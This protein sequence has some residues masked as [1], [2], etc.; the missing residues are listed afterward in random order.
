M[1]IS[2][3]KMYSQTNFP[4]SKLLKMLFLVVFLNLVIPLQKKILMTRLKYH[5][6]NH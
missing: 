1:K 2:D 3:Q 4:P 5:L 6:Y